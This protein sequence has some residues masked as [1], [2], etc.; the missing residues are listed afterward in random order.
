MGLWL[1]LHDLENLHLQGVS[2][3]QSN[4]HDVNDDGI[5]T[6][7]VTTTCEL[8]SWKIQ[9]LRRVISA[10]RGLAYHPCPSSVI[11]LAIAG[12][13]LPRSNSLSSHDV[14]EP[15]NPYVTQTEALRLCANPLDLTISN[16]T[17]RST[18]L[19]I[20]DGL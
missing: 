7:S 8:L 14:E 20:Q 10:L 1:R 5:T 13:H 11:A 2:R 3:N 19:K 9:H 17:S 4:D 15:R 16:S 18:D 12:H 6:M